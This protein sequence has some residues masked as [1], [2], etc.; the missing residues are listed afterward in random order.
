[1]KGIEG[2]T[3]GVSASEFKLNL[4]SLTLKN[5]LRFFTVALHSRRDTEK[6]SVMVTGAGCKRSFTRLT[7]IRL[8][9]T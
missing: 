9:G 8:T 3:P 2:T 5:A 7:R 1:M 6:V 4:N